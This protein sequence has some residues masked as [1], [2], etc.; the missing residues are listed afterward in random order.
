MRGLAE[1][2]KCADF[3][4][5]RS[6]AADAM[7]QRLG[8]GLPLTLTPKRIQDIL[9]FAKSQEK[10]L[11]E[12]LDHNSA[13]A[14]QS[15]NS[16]EDLY[17]RLHGL[18]QTVGGRK[19]YDEAR[20]NYE[21]A[22]RKRSQ[23]RRADL[24]YRL[25]EDVC[26]EL[27]GTDELIPIQ[28]NSLN[29]SEDTVKDKWDK[30]AEYV[31]LYCI[32]IEREK[33][34][35]AGNFVIEYINRYPNLAPYLEEVQ[36]DLVSIEDSPKYDMSDGARSASS[37][38][39]GI[40][41][42]AAD[43]HS[44]RLDK[45]TLEKLHH[46]VQELITIVETIEN[47]QQAVEEL[48]GLISNWRE[49]H[50]DDI[51]KSE[52]IGRYVSKLEALIEDGEIDQ[53]STVRVISHLDDASKAERLLEETGAKIGLAAAER[54]FD[55]VRKLTDDS[56]SHK[57]QLDAAYASIDME[58]PEVLRTEEPKAASQEV[59][60]APEPESDR[61]A[62]EDGNLV[63]LG[64]AV[65]HQAESTTEVSR[66]L[67][68]SVSGVPE[69]DTA[70]KD[71][72]HTSPDTEEVRPTDS[73]DVPVPQ[74]DNVPVAEI[75][76]GI[77][78]AI[79]RGRFSI[80]YHLARTEPEALPSANAV[81]L[82]ACNYATDDPA[83]VAAALPDLADALLQEVRAIPDKAERTSSRDYV[84]LLASAALAPALSAPAGPV[85]QLLLEVES[86]L[87][88]DMPALRILAKTTA[89]FSVLGV[90]LPAGLLQE[91]DSLE[92]WEEEEKSIRREVDSWKENNQDAKLR[93]QPATAVWRRMIGVWEDG[94]RSS[95]GW[96]F[97]ALGGAFGTINAGLILQRINHWR[98]NGEREINKI[99]REKRHRAH[100]RDIEGSGKQDLL[101]K[102]KEAVVLAE[103]WCGLIQGRPTAESEFREA[104]NLRDV[105]HKRSELA[106]NEVRRLATPMASAMVELIS[107]YTSIF[108]KS[109][110]AKPALP[111]RLSDLV[112]GWLLLDPGIRFDESNG[113]PNTPLDINRLMDFVQL[114]A[115]DFYN[116]AIDRAR[117]GDFRDANSAIDFA[118]SSGFLDD[119]NADSAREVI[120]NERAQA[121]KEID[122]RIIGLGELLDNSHARGIISSETFER[123][124]S[125][126]SFVNISDIVDFDEIGSFS[127][128]LD[129]VHI[130]EE[131]D[132]AKGQAAERLGRSLATLKRVSSEDKKRIQGA[133]DEQRFSV[134]EDYIERIR[135]GENLPEAKDSS[136]RPFDN[137]F[138]KFVDDY[139]SFQD[140][141]SD[142]FE[143]VRTAV[144]NRSQAGPIDAARLSENAVRDGGRLLER[145][146]S[147]RAERSARGNLTGLFDAIG[148]T[149]TEVQPYSS[150]GS[151]KA[152]HW[153]LR[154]KPISDRN[155]CR[156]A[157]FGSRARGRYR[158]IV[159][160]GYTTEEKIIQE[161]GGTFSEGGPPNIVLFLNAL[162]TDARRA[163]ALSLS[164]E[165][166]RP[167][168]VLDKALAVFLATRPSGRL[169]AFF[170]CTSAFTCAQPFNPDATEV[171]PEMFFGRDSEQR[172]IRA[173]STETT[174]LVYGGR[175]L[176]KTALLANI[177]HTCR[178]EEPESIVSLIDLKGTTIGRIRP[179]DE[180]WK[181]M[182]K[183]LVERKIVGPTTVRPESIGE[184]VRKWLDG[185]SDRR[186]LL[187]ID[188]A[189]NFLEADERDGYRVLEEIKKLMDEI[190]RRFKERRFKVVFAG[191]HNVQR[192][193]RDPNTPLA[194]L[195]EPIRIGAML[196]ETDREKIE[197]LIRDPLAA[198]GYRFASIDSVIRIAA[199]TN[200][201]PA[202][203]QQFCK[204]LLADLRGDKYMGDRSGPPYMI[205]PE[206]VD[207]VLD[208][209]ETRER[210]CNLF[211]WTIQLDPRYEVLTYLIAERSFDNGSPRLRS[212]SI[213]DISQM[214]REEWPKGFGSDSTFLTFQVLLEEM[215]GLGILRRSKDEEDYTIR[216]RNLRM[217]LGNDDKIKHRLSDAVRKLPPPKFDSALF[218]NTLDSLDDHDLP[219]PITAHQENQ[220]FAGLK[221]VGLVFGTIL[222]G[223]DRVDMALI[224]AG[225]NKGI[226]T[227]KA[228]VA[229][230]DGELREI[231]HGRTSGIDIVLID[232]RSDWEPEIIKRAVDFLAQLDFRER[233]IRPVFLLGPS[234][235]WRWLEDTTQ[236][237][238]RRLLTDSPDVSIEE[239]W[240]TPC[241]RDFTRG[242]LREREAPA[243]AELE[244]PDRS[245]DP[246]WPVV[247]QAAARDK[248]KS[249]I[250]DAIDA[251]LSG[252]DLVSDILLGPETRTAL[253]VLLEYD[254]PM[255]VD[256]L[257]DLASDP[258]SPETVEHMFDWGNRLGIL[259]REEQG[260]RLDSTYAAGLKTVFR[261]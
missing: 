36:R 175:R 208:S 142:A 118:Q 211:L 78:T 201:Y 184:G 136:A 58:L 150:S 205:P 18:L 131:I 42:I 37:L 33:N 28:I 200:Y 38:I 67:A 147:L 117:S 130:H 109:D 132:K 104:R 63:D 152:Q 108:E 229:D 87:D 181:E 68:P 203:A 34:I 224:K 217:L 69:N 121:L 14:W 22:K 66:P 103:R 167:T 172:A 86:R 202:L 241:A 9:K 125:E 100:R 73:E 183:P 10:E 250:V 99:D 79:R 23:I 93:F 230:M 254:D 101:N 260:F 156:L 179:T 146:S 51:E 13:S 159:I 186:I 196:P 143:R 4:E 133:I 29:I 65:E 258:I 162:D 6:Q 12:T 11:R 185:D 157:D 1:I 160:G 31:W 251:A 128:Y 26:Q 80:A 30:F 155:V 89:D 198:L 164:T 15:T 64:P 246:L 135:R 170:D 176:G 193:A 5:T 213:D 46:L 41:G 231:S 126:I 178:A 238:R 54:D 237:D 244:N 168:L 75:E 105:V 171:P 94:E 187:L 249:S 111:M 255:T 259:R 77:A 106:I 39:D 177:A 59:D 44:E 221:V 223:L 127:E 220:I 32:L 204:V 43:L 7:T 62:A 190:E 141:H 140:R 98:D 242:W 207:R 92:K 192:T 261:E 8:N 240:L 222:G 149:E 209:K 182:A 256:G 122:K 247:A 81:K 20:R 234:E 40:K 215:V 74:T 216:T 219:S 194:H 57:T 60:T 245:I 148:F 253:S 232:A 210:I 90:Y 123:L 161:V 226:R 188:E 151:H 158:L 45:K 102:I 16:S 145:W 212:V 91:G 55:S 72:P 96:V 49:Q 52:K 2:A 120:D 112:N 124:R 180:L 174:H 228:A 189:D 50:S 27:S 138:P 236:R 214:A 239:I 206:T 129:D 173:M 113:L 48:R 235:A 115:P 144:K 19:A 191:L 17:H 70:T 257:C 199:E 61:E 134:A 21:N 139:I 154:S 25:W 95:I 114:D 71:T 110:S 137:F 88:D 84:A 82:V 233:V 85:G 107:K 56:E 116:A 153:T 169:A 225:E 227:R 24:F 53:D 3:L 163:L 195:G 166:C 248:S 252:R 97:E 243:C 197:D 83:T 218:R 165:R 76:A 47:E 119:K 35:P